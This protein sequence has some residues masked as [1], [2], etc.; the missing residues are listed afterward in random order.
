MS[1][2]NI[3]GKRCFFFLSISNPLRAAIWIFQ[4]C[5]GIVNTTEGFVDDF[6]KSD[7]SPFHGNL[8][9]VL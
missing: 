9:T 5:K 4:A 1:S 8:S 6:Q 2:S 7:Q 3:H